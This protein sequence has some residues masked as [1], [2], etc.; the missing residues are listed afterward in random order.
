MAKKREI[1]KKFKDL[2]KKLA[3][4]KALSKELADMT[5][6]IDG[7]DVDEAAGAQWPYVGAK[8]ILGTAWE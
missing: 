7:V 3:R 1:D 2:S 8:P 6:M 5:K 4:D